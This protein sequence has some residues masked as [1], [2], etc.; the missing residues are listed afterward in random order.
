MKKNRSPSGVR[1]WSFREGWEGNL[2]MFFSFV[3]HCKNVC[4]LCILI[5]N[6]CRLCHKSGFFTS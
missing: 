1:P 3:F 6:L 4:K 2:E 5:H